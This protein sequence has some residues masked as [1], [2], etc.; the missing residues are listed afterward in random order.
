ML[1][2]FEIHWQSFGLDL[3]KVIR[4]TANER[5][6][7]LRDFYM[8]KLSDF[9]S[10]QLVYVGAWVRQADRF[11]TYWLVSAWSR[12]YRILP[13]Y[14]QKG[15]LLSRVFRG[16]TD[17]APTLPAIPGAKICSYKCLRIRQ[18]RYKGKGIFIYDKGEGR[19]LVSL[20][21]PALR[22]T[23]YGHAYVTFWSWTHE[24]A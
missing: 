2:E 8:Y 22:K 19:R 20:K 11:Q 13:A 14:T 24:L 10:Y 21:S 7:E 1:D 12:R 15:V 6:A 23:A 3:T 18:S 5:N 16:T 4:R 9:R 17:G